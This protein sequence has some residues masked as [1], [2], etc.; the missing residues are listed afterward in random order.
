MCGWSLFPLLSIL[1]L[2]KILLDKLSLL[3]LPLS[4]PN[5]QNN[6]NTN[7]NI[8]T[9]QTKLEFKTFDI[10]YGAPLTNEAG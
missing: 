3:D 6:Q 7:L 2:R 4:A 9:L 1:A 5:D 10:R 8:K